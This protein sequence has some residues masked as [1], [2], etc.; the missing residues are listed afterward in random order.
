MAHHHCGPA[1]GRPESFRE[2]HLAVKGRAAVDVERDLPRRDA[3]GQV[4]VPVA[5]LSATL[6]LHVRV[7]RLGVKVGLALVHEIGRDLGGHADSH[8]RSEQEA[9]SHRRIIIPAMRLPACLLLAAVAQTLSFQAQHRLEAASSP[10]LESRMEVPS[11]ED[12]IRAME[13]RWNEA[14]AH[15]ETIVDGWVLR[16]CSGAVGRNELRSDQG[17]L[18]GT[19][20][21]A[22]KIPLDGPVGVWR[23]GDAP[24]VVA[25]WS[26]ARL[27]RAQSLGLAR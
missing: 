17:G 7:G 26:S 18:A 4:V 22:N 24:N 8:N 9:E 11:V 3:V 14:R 15:A 6:T 5:R 13:T 21:P 12:D 23:R 2:E 19:P 16:G 25:L 1:I 10:A 27:V 20:L